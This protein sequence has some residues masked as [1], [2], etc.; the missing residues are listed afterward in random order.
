MPSGT[1]VDELCGQPEQKYGV[2]CAASVAAAILESVAVQA[3]GE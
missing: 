2:R 1:T 3:G